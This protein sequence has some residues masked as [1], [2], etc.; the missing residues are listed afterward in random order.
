[1]FSKSGRHCEES[2]SALRCAAP[3]Y[4][5]IGLL[6]AAARGS[7]PHHAKT[8]RVGDP[9]A[10]GARKDFFSCF[11]ARLKPGPDTCLVWPEGEG[12]G[13]FHLGRLSARAHRLLD[14]EKPFSKTLCSDGCACQDV[15][16]RVVSER[17][18]C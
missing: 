10:C 14:F 2:F 16:F 7:P 8:A 4:A 13:S 9:G 5:N 6:G 1:M 11:T 12:D 18:F 17:D 3:Q 15:L